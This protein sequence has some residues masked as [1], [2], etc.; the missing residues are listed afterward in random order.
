MSLPDEYAMISSLELMLDRLEQLGQDV[1]LSRKFFNV[2]EWFLSFEGVQVA[3]PRL[4]VTPQE[5]HDQYGELA[6]YF[7]ECFDEWNWEQHRACL[8]E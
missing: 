3:V 6:E 2:G 5:I 1:K 7:L 4:E 8:S